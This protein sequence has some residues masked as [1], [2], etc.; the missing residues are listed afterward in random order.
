M[1][2]LGVVQLGFED[3]VVFPTKVSASTKPSFCVCTL[4]RTLGVLVFV[5]RLLTVSF[6]VV[7]YEHRRYRYEAIVIYVVESRSRA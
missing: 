3:E 5:T 1:V 2:Q 4:H 7:R 6:M